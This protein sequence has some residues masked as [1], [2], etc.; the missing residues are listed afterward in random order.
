MSLGCPVVS[1]NHEA[2]IEAVGDAAVLFNPESSE[3]IKVKI[4]NVVYSEQ[5]KSQ[6]KIKGLSRSNLF[7]WDK[8]ANETLEIYKKVS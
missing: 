1:S 7:S 6:L 3:D 8:C 2:I 5:L 4:E